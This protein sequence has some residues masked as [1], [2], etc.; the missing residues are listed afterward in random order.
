MRLFGRQIQLLVGIPR[1]V[2]VFKQL[3]MKRTAN[4]Y[5]KAPNNTYKRVPQGS[6]ANQF[7]DNFVR[8]FFSG[9][10]VVAPMS[11]CDRYE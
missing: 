7:G 9:T 6:A 4:L 2:S 1:Y 5:F 3:T 11:P 8:Y 10:G